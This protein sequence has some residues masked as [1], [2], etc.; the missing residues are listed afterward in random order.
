MEVDIE[1]G[2]EVGSGR[3]GGGGEYLA[4]RDWRKRLLLPGKEVEKWKWK[5]REC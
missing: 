1:E 3:E 4:S 2:V 5:E